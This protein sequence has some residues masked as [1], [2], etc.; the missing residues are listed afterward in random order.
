MLIDV[1][2]DR[3]CTKV[4]ETVFILNLSY[5]TKKLWLKNRNIAHAHMLV[6]APIYVLHSASRKRTTSDAFLSKRH[7]T[8]NIHAIDLIFSQ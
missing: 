2:N 4:Y 3:A 1:A 6:F 5:E 8:L 7:Y